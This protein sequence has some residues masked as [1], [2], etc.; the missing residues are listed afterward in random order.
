M[1]TLGWFQSLLIISSFMDDTANHTHLLDRESVTLLKKSLDNASISVTGISQCS[2]VVTVTEIYLQLL[3][4]DGI[5]LL[6][7][8]TDLVAVLPLSWFCRGTPHLL[9][10]LYFFWLLIFSS[11]GLNV[12]GIHYFSFWHLTHLKWLICLNIVLCKKL[13]LCSLTHEREAIF[14]TPTLVQPSMFNVSC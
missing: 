1:Q 12:L 5:V 10:H 6:G 2:S 9:Y 3:G 14:S 4:L 8:R 11:V 7:H 13:N